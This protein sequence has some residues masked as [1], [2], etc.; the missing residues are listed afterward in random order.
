MTISDRWYPQKSYFEL[1]FSRFQLTPGAANR[2]KLEYLNG[3]NKDLFITKMPNIHSKYQVPGLE[4]R[5]ENIGTKNKPFLYAITSGQQN[6]KTLIFHVKIGE[7]FHELFLDKVNASNCNFSCSIKGCPAK[8][9]MKLDPKFI[10]FYPN[11]YKL[12]D[13]K[14]RD[15]YDIDREDPE[16]R[17]VDI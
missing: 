9:K 5:L 1:K 13:G 4:V 17:N 2:I 16:L 15:K 3:K 14:T 8:H 10:K 7:T 11:F 6:G 12:K